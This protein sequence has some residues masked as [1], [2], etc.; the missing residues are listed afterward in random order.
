MHHPGVM[1]AAVI[2]IPNERWIERPLA[3]VVLTP[4]AGAVTEDELVLHLDSNFPKFWVPDKI[5]FVD[6]IP[7]TSVGKFDK[8]LLRHRYTCDSMR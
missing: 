1:E 5:A 3:V 6:E 7:K 8:K 2:A 4:D